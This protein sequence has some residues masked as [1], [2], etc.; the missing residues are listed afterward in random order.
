M[1][2]KYTAAVTF[3]NEK[4][5][6]IFVF[7]VVQNCRHFQAYTEYTEEGDQ[8]PPYTFLNVDYTLHFHLGALKI[9]IFKVLFLEGERSGSQQA[10]SVYAFDN[11]DNAG[12]PLSYCDVVGLFGMY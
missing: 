8:W 2:T 4:K 12:Q 9:N 3:L 1:Q 7:R 10:Y 6:A 5:T 11:V